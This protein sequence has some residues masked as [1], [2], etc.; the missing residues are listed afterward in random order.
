MFQLTC[1]GTGSTGNCY[2]VNLGS[3]Y[4]LLDAGVKLEKVLKSVSLNDILFAFI[5]HEHNDHYRY[6]DKLR[7]RLVPIV[8][9]YVI[10]NFL[11]IQ[12][13]PQ[14]E[15]KYRLWTFPVKHGE[16]PC[17]GIVVYD[18]ASKEYLLYMTDFSSCEYDLS[19]FPFTRVM[20]ECNYCESIMGAPKDFKER[21]QINTHVGINGTMAYLDTLDLTHCKDIVL[22]HRS[23]SHGDSITMASRILSKYKIRTGVC[24]QYGGIEWFG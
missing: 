2:L 11:E 4:F 14:F 24:K 18:V 19:M 6:A 9:G 22:I 23:P 3:G 20:I 7:L 16:C 8:R 5:S 15:G 10:P 17:G 21:R 13:L 1:F 12:A